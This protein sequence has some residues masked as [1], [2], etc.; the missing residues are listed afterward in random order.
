M[1]LAERL[2]QDM[3]AALKSKQ[4][5]RL[6][7]LRMALAAV[8]YKEVERRAVLDDAGVQ[9]VLST[10]IKQREDSA[11]Q[12]DAGGRP[13]LAAKERGEIAILNEYLPQAASDEEIEA[14]VRQ[15]IAATGAQ[16][17][18]DLGGVMKAAM[19]QFAAAGRRADGKI[20]NAAARRL[21]GA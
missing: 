20:V 18:K 11:Q 14:A 21:L 13:E 12:F 17:A 9:Q 8:K 1:T 10:L 19:A 7:T 6:S 5:L 4:D 16:G 2:R 3:I 15:A